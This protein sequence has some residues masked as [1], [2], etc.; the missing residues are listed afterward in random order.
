MS[1]DQFLVAFSIWAAA[2]FILVVVIIRIAIDL[3]AE[4][5]YSLELRRSLERLR[6]KE[7]LTSE[8]MSRPQWTRSAEPKSEG[9]E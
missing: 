4:R 9:G 1:T 5:L 3:G 7:R 6:A 2:M 8:P